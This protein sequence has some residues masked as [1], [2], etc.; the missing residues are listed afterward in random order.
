MHVIALDDEFRRIALAIFS[1]QRMAEEAALVFEII[2]WLG[3]NSSLDGFIT[4]RIGEARRFEAFAGVLSGSPW[5]SGAGC[6]CG[7]R[8]RDAIGAVG[9]LDG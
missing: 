1:G 6:W 7:V 9:V 8:A 3:H 2:H 5:A 4:A